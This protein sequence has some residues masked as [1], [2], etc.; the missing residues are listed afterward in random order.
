MKE[1]LF[2]SL[3]FIGVVWVLVRIELIRTSHKV[4]NEMTM[5]DGILMIAA[6]IN[7]IA[8]VVYGIITGEVDAG[9]A[10][11]CLI[12]FGGPLLLIIISWIR[13]SIKE[14]KGSTD[15]YPPKRWDEEDYGFSKDN[16]IWVGTCKY[17]MKRLAAKNGK[18]FRWESKR[19]DLPKKSGF[20]GCKMYEIRIIFDEKEDV[21]YLVTKKG[22][23]KTLGTWN[24]PRGYDAWICSK[25]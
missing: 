13:V 3:V 11:S 8:L 25:Y 16:P 15:I 23:N 12:V 18:P 4:N 7:L 10:V 6:G 24:A 17:Y 22:L 1:F 14:N 5:L 21:I 9:L 2:G 19:I 20:V